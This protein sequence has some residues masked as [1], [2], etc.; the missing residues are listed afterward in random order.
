MKAI[1]AAAGWKAAGADIGLPG[2][3]EPF[4]PL[5]DGTT[6]LS[7]TA[8]AFSDNE[9]EIYTAIAGRD[10]PYSRYIRW[11]EQKFLPKFGHDFD[12]S[13]TPWTPERYA[14]AAQFGAVLE[15]PDPGGWST[16]LD[17]FCQSMD[18]IGAD[19]WDGLIL[20]CG[21][22]LVHREVLDFIAGLPV[23]FVF[24]LTAFHAYF[25]L[26][27]DGARCFRDYAEPYRRF[28]SQDAWRNEKNWAPHY[29]GNT[30]LAQAGFNIFGRETAPVQKWTDIDIAAIYGDALR[31]V[32]AES[33]G[34]ET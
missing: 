2:C 23:P 3:P 31:W 10:Y 21:D 14:Y 28:R 17:T 32:A 15:M 22:M 34:N 25:G 11:S 8:Q 27:A 16:S 26:D 18:M 6:T 5:G 13:A 1:I 20:A 7:R 4:L 9:C 29:W 24:S 19:N 33:D 12:W 30:I